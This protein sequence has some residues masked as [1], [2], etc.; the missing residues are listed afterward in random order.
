MLQISECF[1]LLLFFLLTW[2]MS[3]WLNQVGVYS[4]FLQKI[5][6]KIVVC[7]VVFLTIFKTL[8]TKYNSSMKRHY[9]TFLVLGFWVYWFIQN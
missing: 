9:I 3:K 8:G 7:I 2:S 4:L 6:T 5:K 1:L